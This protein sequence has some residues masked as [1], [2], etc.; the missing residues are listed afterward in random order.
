MPEPDWY[1]PSRQSPLAIVFLLLKYLRRIGRSLW[2]LLVLLVLGRGESKMQWI[3]VLAVV[4]TSLQLVGALLAYFRFFFYLQGDQ[5]V[6]E[7]GVLARKRTTIPLERIQGL[8]FEQNFLHRLLGLVQ[9]QVDTAGSKSSDVT[10]DALEMAR[11]VSLRSFILQQQQEIAPAAD[12][13]EEVPVAVAASQ[14]LLHLAPVALLRVGLTQN[15]LQTTGLILGSLFGLWQLSGDLWEEAGIEQ[16]LPRLLGIDYRHSV[17]T[18]VVLLVLLLLA[19]FVGTLL[20][21][22]L[23]YFDLRLRQAADGF[24]LTAGLLQRREQVARFHKIQFVRWS[25]NPLQALLGLHT[26]R[27]FQAGSDAQQ[28]RQAIA[29]PGCGMAEVEQVLMPYASPADRAGLAWAEISPRIVG[30]RVLWWGVVP[31]LLAAPVLVLHGKLVSVLLVCWPL[32]VWW[33]A[34]RYRQRFRFGV[35]AGLLHIRSGVLGHRDTLLHLRKVQGVA[36]GQSPYQ[37]RHGLAC[38][39]LYTAAGSLELPYLALDTAR[40]LRDYLLC[41][42]EADRGAWM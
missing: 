11:A 5:L 25:V 30:R 40:H 2:P 24:Y 12:D 33:L 35:N 13:A 27:L 37:R 20:R 18:I 16:L 39:E 31:L 19:S 6:V 41:R 34:R 36:L 8:T 9:V 15:H 21:T 14:E 17:G 29:I 26:V 42:V 7:Q 1:S 4:L 10:F 28:A 23:R 3:L 22:V 38:L 32:L